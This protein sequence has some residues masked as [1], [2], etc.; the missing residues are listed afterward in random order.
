LLS[1]PL[2]QLRAVLGHSGAARNAVQ[3]AS[4]LVILLIVVLSKPRIT[5]PHATALELPGQLDK[6]PRVMVIELV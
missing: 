2:A 3:A 4:L 5:S 6:I 1:T